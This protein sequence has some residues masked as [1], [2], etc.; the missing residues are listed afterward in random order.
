M[1]IGQYNL[2]IHSDSTLNSSIFD[3]INKYLSLIF[4]VWV[5][6]FLFYFLMRHPLA[7]Q[8][9]ELIFMNRVDIDAFHFFCRL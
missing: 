3:A 6:L 9:I 4:I 1:E 7:L 2:I 5:F 8:H